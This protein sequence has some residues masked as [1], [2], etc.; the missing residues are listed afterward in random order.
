MGHGLA[1][2]ASGSGEFV[3]VVTVQAAWGRIEV[4]T[5]VASE[6]RS[7]MVVAA[8]FADGFAVVA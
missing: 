8:A 7:L 6:V 3:T 5:E 2:A 1:L 4:V